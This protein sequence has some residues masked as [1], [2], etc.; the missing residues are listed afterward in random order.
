ML[1]LVACGRS[2]IM[3]TTAS[4]AGEE[5][6]QTLPAAP[7]VTVPDFKM[8][9][10]QGAAVLGG[11]E[12]TFGRVFEHGKP[13]VLNFWA[14]LCPPCRAEMP[15]FQAV[16]DEYANEVIVVGVDLGPFIGLGSEADA[17]ALLQELNIHYPAAAAVDPSP[18]QL[19]AVRGMPTTVF[20]AADGTIVEQYTGLLTEQQ[21]RNMVADFV[22]EES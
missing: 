19:Y 20:F 9:A 3:R 8:V 5:G 2:T 11:R 21:L 14:G 10:Y 13:V 12:T 18:L 7:Q 1:L 16:A 4:D 17:T 6:Q 15:A 22:R